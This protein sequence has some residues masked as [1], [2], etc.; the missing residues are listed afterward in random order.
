M[1]RPTRSTITGVVYARYGPPSSEYSTLST[2]EPPASVAVSVTLALV[3]YAPSAFLSPL[4]VA[5][6]SGGVVSP[7]GGATTVK[8]TAFSAATFPA[9]SVAR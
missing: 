6:V 7:A 8:S 4:T 9:R 2:P 5:V 3:M 1:C